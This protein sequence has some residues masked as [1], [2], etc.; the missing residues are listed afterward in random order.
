VLLGTSYP[1]TIN[2]SQSIYFLSLFFLGALGLAIVILWTMINRISASEVNMMQRI[3][4]GVIFERQSNIV[5]RQEYWI[6][7]FQI[8]LPT[9]QEDGKYEPCDIIHQHCFILNQVLSQITAIRTQ[10]SSNI[11]YTVE[12]I[13]KLLH[14]RQINTKPDTEIRLRRGLFDFIGSISKSLF[15]TAT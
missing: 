12:I 13:H 2:I 5:L 14:K 10:V 11:N 9:K 8:P 4:Y 15:G 6:H 3:N 1:L 7:T